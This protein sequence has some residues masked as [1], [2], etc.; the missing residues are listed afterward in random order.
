MG[1]QEQVETRIATELFTGRL[2]ERIGM[3]L[4]SR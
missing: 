3:L 2:A 1:S 4:A